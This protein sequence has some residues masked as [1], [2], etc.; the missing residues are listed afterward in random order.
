MK[1]CQIIWLENNGQ[2]HSPCSRFFFT[3]KG[4]LPTKLVHHGDS[5]FLLPVARLN[6]SYG[7]CN[8]EI[9]EKLDTRWISSPY[10]APILIIPFTHSTTYWKM[11]RSYDRCRM[12]PFVNIRRL[13]S[14]DW[15]SE[16][17]EQKNRG[18][19]GWSDKLLVKGW[20]DVYTHL[21]ITLMPN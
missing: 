18:E 14:K 4:P 10:P 3:F 6:C 16:A 15:K 20:P 5:D 19:D 1:I 11:L 17:P 12:Y 2:L 13:C 21:C 7:R 8:T 9:T